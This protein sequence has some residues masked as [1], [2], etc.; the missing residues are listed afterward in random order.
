VDNS[1]NTAAKPPAGTVALLMGYFFAEAMIFSFNA[2]QAA[3]G[4]LAAVMAEQTAIAAAPASKT[5]PRFSSVM[6]P[7]AT[8]AIAVFDRNSVAWRT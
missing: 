5:P 4:S 6:P 3:A 8:P 1:L 2:R 7:T